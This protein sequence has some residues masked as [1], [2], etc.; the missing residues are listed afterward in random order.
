MTLNEVIN[1]VQAAS[2]T[3]GFIIAVASPFANLWPSSPESKFIQALKS[4]NDFFA[5][6]WR[7]IYNDWNKK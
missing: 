2:A 4:A 6:N 1:I 7:V 5:A 3:V